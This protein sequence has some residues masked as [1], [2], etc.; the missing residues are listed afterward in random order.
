MTSFGAAVAAGRGEAHTGGCLRNRHP[1]KLARGRLWFQSR[2]TEGSDS[3]ERG[4]EC[5]RIPERVTLALAVTPDSIVRGCRHLRR[6]MAKR[7]QEPRTPI[8]S[9]QDE[10]R[11][12]MRRERALIGRHPRPGPWAAIRPCV[13]ELPSR[14]GPTR[15]RSSLV[16]NLRVVTFRTRVSATGPV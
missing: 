13:T 12:I 4:I 6:P 11:P 10:R 7:V 2:E 9:S 5:G 14:R 16:Y 8:G 3:A 1:W 15:A